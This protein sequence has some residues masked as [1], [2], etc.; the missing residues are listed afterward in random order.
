[1]VIA[2]V[3]VSSYSGY[4]RVGVPSHCGYARVVLSSTC[5]YCSCGCFFLIVVIE[6]TVTVCV[7]IKRMTLSVRVILSQPVMSGDP[8]ALVTQKILS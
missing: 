5:G 1:M 4:C 3:V 2:R 8:R 6:R 7:V